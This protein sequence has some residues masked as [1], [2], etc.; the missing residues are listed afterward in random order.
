MSSPVDGKNWCIQRFSYIRINP[1]NV[2]TIHIIWYIIFFVITIPIRDK[3]YALRFLKENEFDEIHFF[4]DKT[5]EGGNDHEIF[6]HE[7]TIGHTVISPDDTRDQCQKL[8]L[9]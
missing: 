5:F 7:R 6:A 8:F 3:T 2:V 1:K 4:G 9:S